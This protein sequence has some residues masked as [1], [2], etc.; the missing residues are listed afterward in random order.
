MRTWWVMVGMLMLA[1]VG[2]ERPRVNGR[3]AGTVDIWD[4]GTVEIAD[5][6]PDTHDVG[7][8]ETPDIGIPVTP[9]PSGRGDCDGMAAT[10]CETDLNTTVQHCGRCGGACGVGQKCVAGRCECVPGRGDCDGDRNGPNGCEVDLT[11]TRD[12]CERCGNPCPTRANSTPSCVSGSCVPVC[13]PGF[14][15]CDGREDNGCE[16]NVMTDANHCGECPVVC[17]ARPRAFPT[18]VAGRCGIMCM[19]SY[20]LDCDTNPSNG[21]EADTQSDS[22]HCGRCNRPCTDATRPNCSGG[23]CADGCAP[24]LNLCQCINPAINATRC[25]A[26]CSRAVSC[27][28]GEFCLGGVC[29]CPMGQTLCGTQCAATLEDPA[30]CGACGRRC[31]TGASCVSGQC[32]CPTGQIVC[33]DTCVDPRRDRSHCGRCNSPCGYCVPDAQNPTRIVC[34]CGGD[35]PDQECCWPNVCGTGLRCEGGRCRR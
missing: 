16:V 19:S 8:V 34:R 13:T 23:S 7:M 32:Q 2:L 3:D 24:P 17:P 10:V 28:P 1:C 5:V 9:C 35:G 18:C 21:C 33:G 31:P 15:N 30:N 26:D 14:G 6:V 25:G 11:S 22:S 4:G 20:V 12:H 27:R 29:G